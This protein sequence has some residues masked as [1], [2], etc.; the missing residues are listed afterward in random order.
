MPAVPAPARGPGGTDTP[1]RAVGVGGVLRD[2]ARETRRPPSASSSSTH[3]ANTVG[4]QSTLPG[5]ILA[6]PLS[7]PG[8]CRTLFPRDV[9]SVR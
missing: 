8:Q 4:Q 1:T 7:S 5:N 6:V 9:N 3:N 2:A